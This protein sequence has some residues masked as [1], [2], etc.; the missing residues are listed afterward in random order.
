MH[1]KEWLYAH[2]RELGLLHPWMTVH[3]WSDCGPHFR[4]NQVISHAC[5]NL[6]QQFKTHTN[7]SY[8]LECHAKS[9]LDS[10]GG[11]LKRIKLEAA[12]QRW[13]RT[14]GHAVT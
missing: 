10:K 4:A 3:N 8:G 11:L 6:P 2:L 7:I 12:S 1:L 13:L 5:I 9:R 14:I